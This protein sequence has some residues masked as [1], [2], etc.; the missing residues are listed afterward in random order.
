MPDKLT[1][2]RLETYVK[3]AKKR[4]DMP[5]TC[6]LEYLAEAM[7]IIGPGMPGNYGLVPIDFKEIAAYDHLGIYSMSERRII[8]DLS[9]AY[10]GQF[11]I[12]KDSPAPWVKG[13]EDMETHNFMAK[14]REIKENT[15]SPKSLNKKKRGGARA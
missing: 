2:S 5:A 9:R 10:I 14:M 6:G 1:K 8:R 12:S 13:V 7:L 11:N 4:P 15:G 3:V